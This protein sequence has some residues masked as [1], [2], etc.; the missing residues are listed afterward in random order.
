M[1][2][3]ECVAEVGWDQLGAFRLSVDDELVESAGEAP[4]GHQVPIRALDGSKAS[5]HSEYPAGPTAC[6]HASLKVEAHVRR[7][8]Q[9][10]LESRVL[11]ADRHLHAV[12]RTIGFLGELDED[13]A[14]IGILNACLEVVDAAVGALVEKGPTGWWSV[15]ELGLHP[16][17]LLPLLSDE[18]G[19]TQCIRDTDAGVRLL[20]VPLGASSGAPLMVVLAEWSVLDSDVHSVLSTVSRLGR[21]ALENAHLVR[22]AAERQRLRIELELA[23]RT[24]EQLMPT[25]APSWPGLEVVGHSR[26]SADCGGDYFDWFPTVGRGFVVCV[27]DVSG[28]GLNAA[29]VM[30]TL[31]GYLVAALRH[32]ESLHTTLADVCK[33]LCGILEPWQFVTVFLAEVSMDGQ[34][35]R[36]C[37]AGHES[38]LLVRARGSVERLTADAPPL[39]IDPAL[40]PEMQSVSLAV[41]DQLVIPTDGLAEAENEDG[42]QIGRDV[43]EEWVVRC[44]R[45]N[46]CA[47]E[48]RDALLEEVASHRGDAP[49]MDDET[50]VV[51]RR[52]RDP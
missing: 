23:G 47:A 41:G 5:L 40:T 10:Q 27:A 39:G 2:S 16:E 24:Q 46:P 26:P 17:V 28:H 1:P 49:Q 29:I 33:M 37:N 35:L 32:V 50:L 43:F 48:T 11:Q 4:L 3:G 18:P 9:R 20:L 14:R 51:I 44:V 34:T 8:L 15:V 31:R 6:E 38:G 13:R 21:V 22:E 36:Y 7:A 25:D 12:E 45:E 30:A 19:T 52:R 42:I